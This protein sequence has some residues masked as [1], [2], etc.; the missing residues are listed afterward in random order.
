MPPKGSTKRRRSKEEIVARLLD[1]QG[2]LRRVPTA[3]D[4][5][6]EARALQDGRDPFPTLTE[7]LIVFGSLRSA[8]EAAGMQCSTRGGG[9]EYSEQ[10]MIESYVALAFQKAKENE[11]FFLPSTREIDRFA[12][13]GNCR[14]K[15]RNYRIAFG[16]LE[17]VFTA[18]TKSTDTVPFALVEKA[19]ERFIQGQW[20]PKGVLRSS[21]YVLIPYLIHTRREL[22]ARPDAM[23]MIE[24][25]RED[26][27]RP[28]LLDIQRC[29]HS[30]DEALEVVK[31]HA[32]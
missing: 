9:I 30:L 1:L 6:A 19:T 26:S 29:F 5:R 31:L 22:K 24:R 23:T 21:P 8:Q 4:V 28:S 3:N 13:S 16:G 27:R 12:R 2:K 15:A 14:P 7:I 32:E 25:S 11:G 10:R 17:P 20:N 18:M